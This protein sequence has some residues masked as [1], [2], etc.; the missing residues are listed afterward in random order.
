MFFDIIR[1]LILR[2]IQN[3]NKA[4]KKRGGNS[5]D[6]EDDDLTRSPGRSERSEQESRPASPTLLAKINLATK[7]GS[8]PK[9][10]NSL[11]HVHNKNSYH[12]FNSFS[13]KQQFFNSLRKN[14]NSFLKETESHHVNFYREC[15]QKNVHSI[16]TF[17]HMINNGVVHINCYRMDRVLVEAFVGYIMS[18]C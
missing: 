12:V 16:P 2:Q 15:H 1:K 6:D 17:S 8:N 18:T 10:I 14:P 5:D 13:T 3:Q 4:L 11:N 9:C 7:V